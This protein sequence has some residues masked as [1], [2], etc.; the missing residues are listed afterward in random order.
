VPFNLRSCVQLSSGSAEGIGDCTLK[1]GYCCYQ[2]ERNHEQQKCIFCR[3]LAALVAP[4]SR[5]QC[6]RP[7]TLYLA[8]LKATTLVL[9][10]SD[11]N[12]KVAGLKVRSGLSRARN[13]L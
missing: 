12:R 10:T 8:P 7:R 2:S 1:A 3:I 6:S 9:C 13:R 4:N 11:V 5:N